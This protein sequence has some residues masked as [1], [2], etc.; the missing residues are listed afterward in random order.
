MKKWMKIAVP[1]LIGAVLASLLP[2]VGF[3]FMGMALVGLGSASS[4]DSAFCSSAPAAALDV[5]P[6]SVPAVE[7]FTPPQVAGAVQIVHVGAQIGVGERGQLIALMTAMQESTLG[8]GTS[9]PGVP[10]NQPNADNDAGWFQQRITPGWYGSLAEVNDAATGARIFYEGR[11]AKFDGDYGTAGGS[12]RHIPGLLDIKGWETMSL[13]QAAQKVQVSNFPDAYAAH[14]S[15]ARRLL[16]AVA[17]VPV[18]AATASLTDPQLGCGA[19]GQLPAVT[20]IDGLPT[21]EQLYG[22]SASIACPAG[23]TDLGVGQGG[24]NGDRVPIRLCSITGTVCTGSD[25][26]AGEL[27]GKARGEVILNSV[28]APFFMQWLTEVRAQGVNPL[29]NSSY[30][31][32]ATQERLWDGGRNRNSTRPGTSNHQMGAAVDIAGLGGSYERD[33]C[34]GHA[35]DGGCMSPSPKWTVYHDVGLKYG[36]T[37]LDSEYWHLQW[38]GGPK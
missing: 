8:T 14:E 12:N 3:V 26:G 9:E 25:C 4:P 19:S 5:D 15:E 29:F 22:N 10:W 1:V 36:A 32:W 33:M 27:N 37:F 13:T 2:V 16:A 18:T 35:P 11:T 23:T 6:A 30:R 21:P 38:V 20:A 17:G 24:H 7:G 31:T 34:S 28:V